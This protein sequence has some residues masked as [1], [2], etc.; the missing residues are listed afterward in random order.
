MTETSPAMKC[1]YCGAHATRNVN[2]QNVCYSHIGAA[3]GVKASEVP[4]VQ[5]K[6][7]PTLD[8]MHRLMIKREAA[9]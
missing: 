1:E 2:H 4:H 8:A 9:L 5:L 7:G 3:L 6:A